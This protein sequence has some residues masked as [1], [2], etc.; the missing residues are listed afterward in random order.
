MIKINQLNKEFESRVRLGIM[1]ILMV[2]D[3]VD[4]S[5]MKALL[6]VTD[7][8]LA[9]HS[10]ALEKANFIEVKKEFIGKKPKTSY[11]VTQAGRSSFN[12]H[13]DALEKLIGR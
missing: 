12:D 7:G 4:F 11:R 1:S 13:L 10:N 8:N 5:E 6:E 3:W 9:S 2:N